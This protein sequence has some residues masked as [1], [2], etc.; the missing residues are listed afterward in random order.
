[1]LR[2]MGASNLRG[3]AAGV[4]GSCP[5]SAGKGAFAEAEPGV[6][7]LVAQLCLTLSNSMDCSPPGSSVHGFLQAKIMESVAIPFSRASSRATDRT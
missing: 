2:R 7:V 3:L 6:C 1:M 4:A 5:A